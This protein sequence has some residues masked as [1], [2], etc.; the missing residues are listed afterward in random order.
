MTNREYKML[1][2]APLLSCSR[3][4]PGIDW[5]IHNMDVATFCIL[6]VSDNILKLRVIEIND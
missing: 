6:N 1:A 3:M 5:L 4:G 2:N